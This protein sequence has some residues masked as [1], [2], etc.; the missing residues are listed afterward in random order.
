MERRDYLMD[1]INEIGLFIAKLLGRLRLHELENEEDQM[2]SEAKDALTVQF[3]WELEDL[4]FMENA[5]FISLME[6]NLLAEQHYE[7]LSEVFHLLGDHAL[8]HQTLLRKELY[9]Q[10]ALWLLQYVDRQS[11]DYSMVRRD[12]IVNLEVKI[13][14]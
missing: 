12:K 1:Q 3:G 5:P 10:K 7:Q 13:K 14:Y 2:L 4:L 8:E 11:S 6:E 9:Y